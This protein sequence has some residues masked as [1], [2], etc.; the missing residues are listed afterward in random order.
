[1]DRNFVDELYR[2]Y[3][4]SVFRRACLLMND[5]D[6]GK[7]VMQ[8]VFLRAFEARVEY[9][10]AEMNRRMGQSGWTRQKSRIQDSGNLSMEV[11]L[12]QLPIRTKFETGKS[13]K[14]TLLRIECGRNRRKAE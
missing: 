13:G 7:D 10:A 6:A 8:E 4:A 9:T 2:R 14:G 5:R 12:F 1:M 11:T 3:S